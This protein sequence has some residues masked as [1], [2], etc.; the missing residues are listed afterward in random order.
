[1]YSES[2]AQTAKVEVQKYLLRFPILP[3][4]IK[5]FGE[6]MCGDLLMMWTLGSVGVVLSLTNTE[7][8]H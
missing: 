8:K 2:F 5:R 4:Q 7:P 6:T 1:M 3:V